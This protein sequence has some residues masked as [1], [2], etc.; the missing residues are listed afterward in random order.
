[1]IWLV[2]YGLGPVF[3][4]AG[5]FV[6]ALVR[7]HVELDLDPFRIVFGYVAWILPAAMIT[8]LIYTLLRTRGS[9][10]LLPLL[11]A[12]GVLSYVAMIFFKFL[13]APIDFDFLD[14]ITNFL[15]VHLAAILGCWAVLRRLA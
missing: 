4:R 1:M 3:G 8:A 14:A 11:L 5:S 10:P 12:G 15:A 7:G 2:V 9:V 13:A 6:L